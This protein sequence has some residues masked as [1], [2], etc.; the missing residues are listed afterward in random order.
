MPSCTFACRKFPSLYF[1]WH[2]LSR[3]KA[4]EPTCPS[5]TQ[6][7][8][9]R[10]WQSVWLTTI[11]VGVLTHS[12]CQQRPAAPVAKVTEN[13]SEQRDASLARAAETLRLAADWGQFSAAL[14]DLNGPLAKQAGV[15][16][17]FDEK[18]R[19]LV[20]ELYQLDT[21]EL[22]QLEASLMRPLD[23]A[24]LQSCFLFRDAARSLEVAGL[25]PVDQ[26]V[27]GCAW[28]MRRVLL[29]EQQDE[30]LPPHLVLQ[31][32]FGDVRDRALVAL[33]LLR[34]WQI[35]GCFVAAPKKDGGETLLLG[36]VLPKKEGV[37][38]ALFDPRL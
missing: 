10:L 21:A 4:W 16:K 2:S 3:R 24:Y 18:T 26:A 36:L 9:P 25:A 7:V 37:D 22:E 27:L 32:G 20:K 13:V 23:A 28:A 5:K 1:G 33:E 30:G 35:D 8:P 31:R 17:P 29:H 11:L 12:G 15:T 19:Q 6:N 34:H 14:N 38:I